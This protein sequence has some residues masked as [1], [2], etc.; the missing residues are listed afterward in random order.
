MFTACKALASWVTIL[1]LQ[2][3]NLESKEPDPQSHEAPVFPGWFCLA[4]Q[5]FSLQNRLCPF[6]NV[7]LTLPSH[8]VCAAGTA[9]PVPCYGVS[10]HWAG[11]SQLPSPVVGSSAAQ[12]TTDRNAGSVLSKLIV[13]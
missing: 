6:G 4:P 11:G 3:Q 9:A 8:E 12:P 5:I 2:T 10:K 7:T 13:L 1:I